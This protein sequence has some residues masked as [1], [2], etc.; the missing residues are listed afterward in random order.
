MRR[1]TV[2]VVLVI[3]LVLSMGSLFAASQARA[4]TPL[5]IRIGY[6]ATPDWLLFTARALKLFEKAGLAPTYVKF[7]AGAP[8]IAAAQSKNI[9]V[10]DL[11]TVP[12]LVGLSQGVDWVMIGIST[13]GAYTEGVAAR[14][15]SGINTLADL[16]GKR[17]G[18]FKGSTAQY[19]LMM[20][21]RQQGIR[22]DQVTLLDMP[23]AEQ[24]A[25]L[26]NK[27]IDAA[28]VWEP[29]MQRM[30]HEANAKIIAT[31]GDFGI[32]TNVTGY[33][34]R[35]DW[36]RDNKEAAVRFLRALLMAYDVLQKD[37]SIGVRTLAGEM[38]IKEAWVKEIYR[39][40]PP[41]NMHWS[42]DHGYRYSLVEGSGFHR[43][44]GYLAT[45]LL[46]EKV[47]SKEVDVS[48]VLDVS[49]VTEA[50]RTWKTQ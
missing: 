34:A 45:F 18:Y 8:M 27:E 9:D 1:S 36:L 20:A 35:R 19:G 37:P 28:M 11:G 2:P 17:I 47:I 22:L 16:R 25:A 7:V 12:F 30:V 49:V 44:L 14:K 29:W 50:L 15:D 43:R 39:D 24:L 26:A 41:P 21:L 33:A 38:G 48:E 13:E 31:E 6:Q 3:S 4:Q 5:P 42:T 32:Y 46:E 10:A 23:P 40:A